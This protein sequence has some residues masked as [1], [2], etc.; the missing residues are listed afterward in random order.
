MAESVEIPRDAENARVEP[1]GH[2]VRLTNLRKVYW[3]E[4]GITKGDLL[5]YYCA[6]SPA[7]LPHLADRAMVMKRYPNGIH[8]KFFFMKRTPSHR[9]EWLETCAIMHGSGNVIHFPVV[10]DLATLL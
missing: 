2:P 9:P 7:L 4:L 10:Q 5:R 8:G 3:P 1:G 6:V